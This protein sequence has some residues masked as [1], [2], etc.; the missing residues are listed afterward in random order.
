MSEPR[1]SIAKA[2][3]ATGA[4]VALSVLAAGPALSA[5]AAVTIDIQATGKEKP[6]L[7]RKKFKPTSIT[8]GNTVTDVANPAGLPPK[9]TEVVT[10][11]DPK[12]IKFNPDAVPTCDISQLEGQT[13]QGAIDA[14][15]KAKVGSGTAVA[16]LPFGTGGSPVAYPSVITAFNRAGGDGI[17]FHARSD[18]LGT[19]IVLDGTLK[20]T[21]LTVSVPPIGGGV[22][23]SPEFNVRV[24][25]KDSVMARCKDGKINYTATFSFT[26]APQASA[27]DAQPCKKKPKR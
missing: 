1:G 17:L 4:L 11:F 8:F 3:L 26:D 23:S 7:D 14:C 18:A 16:S 24:Q 15:P 6:K 20:G 9:V 27:S 10:K 12:D 5:P 21:T 25:A 19:A 22:G 13:T 2:T